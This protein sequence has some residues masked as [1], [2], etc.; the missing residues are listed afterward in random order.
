MVLLGKRLRA[1][2]S[3]GDGYPAPAGQRPGAHADLFS[4]GSWER[5]TNSKATANIQASMMHAG[6]ARSK[7]QPQAGGEHVRESDAVGPGQELRTGIATMSTGANKNMWNRAGEMLV[8]CRFMD[9]EYCAIS[10]IHVRSFGRIG[11]RMGSVI[12]LLLQL[13][14]TTVALGFEGTQ[15]S[16]GLINSSHESAL[17]ETIGGSAVR[18]A[19][20]HTDNWFQRSESEQRG[21]KAC[22]DDQGRPYSDGALARIGG[23]VK[24][25]HNG[26]WE[27]SPAATPQPIKKTCKDDG[28]RAYLEGA[29]ARIRGA[30]RVCRDGAWVTPRAAGQNVKKACKDEA[31][32]P[33]P[34]GALGTIRGALM[35]CQDGKWV[36]PRDRKQERHR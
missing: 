14:F 2:H 35:V 36:P 3:Q 15:G 10:S 5:R 11:G 9:G 24:V 33:Y 31:G 20:R 17:G 28:G 1:G 32:R 12:V 30:T 29:R 27:V 13:A 21:K 23:V 26:T 22:N 34:V 25:C 4:G 18:P 19:T 16:R 7:R 8:D 6:H